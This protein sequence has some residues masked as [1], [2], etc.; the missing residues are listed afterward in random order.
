MTRS[1]SAARLYPSQTTPQSTLP[2][3]QKRSQSPFLKNELPYLNRP[4]QKRKDP[5]FSFNSST[6]ECTKSNLPPKLN[7]IQIIN[8]QL[9]AKTA[10]MQTEFLNMKV[11][12]DLIYNEQAHLV[13]LFKDYLIHDD[14]NEF[15]KR[16]YTQAESFLRIP[17][18]VTFY[19]QYSEV[20]PNYVPLPE[21]V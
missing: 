10:K 13:T 7:P 1:R 6:K 15:L 21:S 19:S 8:A 11:V 4:K 17:K 3:P 20:F 12:N 14:I 2:Q 18:L 16:P 5:I 9:N